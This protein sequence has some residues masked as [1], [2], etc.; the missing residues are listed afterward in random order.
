MFR[1]LK[2]Y[3]TVLLVGL[4]LFQIRLLLRMRDLPHVLVWLSPARVTGERDDSEMGDLT[5][6]VDR[7]LQIVP[8]SRKGNSFPRSLALYWFAR[9]LGYP[10]QFHCGIRMQHIHLEW[11]AWLTWNGAPFREVDQQW[12]TYTI[13]YSHPPDAA[14]PG[15]REEFSLHKS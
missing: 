3:W 14:L 8:S 9:R 2:K 7:W 1:L 13:T 11:H 15:A 5:Y 4:V 6:Y 12:E 10:V